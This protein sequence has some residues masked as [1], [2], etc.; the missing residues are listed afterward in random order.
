MRWGQSPHSHLAALPPS[1]R[2]AA[3]WGRV[4]YPAVHRLPR[5]AACMAM[6]DQVTTST[7]PPTEHVHSCIHYHNVHTSVWLIRSMLSWQLYYYYYHYDSSYAHIMVYLPIQCHSWKK[8]VLK[9]LSIL[10]AGI[11][12][13]SSLL[14]NMDYVF[15]PIITWYQHISTLHIKII[16][17]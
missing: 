8:P 1:S 9:S 5:V 17:V 7:H 15:L 3:M 14:N 12:T 2:E 13:R 4:W 6:E 11:G 10:P 16:R